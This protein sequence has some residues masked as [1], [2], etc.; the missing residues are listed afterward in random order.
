MFL[1]AHSFLANIGFNILIPVVIMTRFTEELGALPALLIALAF[2]LAYG[3]WDWYKIKTINFYSA[4]GLV[5]VLLTGSIGFLALPAQYLAYKEAAIPLILALVFALSS[6]TR[7]DATSRFLG[8]V[9]DIK[10]LHKEYGKKKLDFERPLSWM[11]RSFVVAL[12][13]SAIANYLLTIIIVTGEPATSEFTAQIGHMTAL[14]FPI[15]VLPI[16]II[17]FASLFF[18]S[19]HV[20]KTTRKPL[21][22]FLV[23]KPIDS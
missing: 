20:Q 13:F 5:S 19:R 17:I 8:S 16:I 23:K 21:E 14:S 1:M 7:F 9:L 6:Y 11:R 4:L 2:P 22:E 3:L 10:K 12:L 18:L 15:I